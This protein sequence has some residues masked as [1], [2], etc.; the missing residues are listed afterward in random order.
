MYVTELDNCVH[1]V[2]Y[3]K[4]GKDDGLEWR[5][6]SG[7]QYADDGCPMASSEEDMSVIM[8]KVNDCVIEFGFK[9]HEKKSKLMCINDVHTKLED[10]D[11]R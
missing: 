9:L 8:E 1:G 5:S 6:Q 7:F 3:A 4:S 10:V 2:N 11:G